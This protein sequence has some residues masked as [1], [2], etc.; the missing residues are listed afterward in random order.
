VVAIHLLALQPMRPRTF[1]SRRNDAVTLIWNNQ[2][3]PKG[4]ESP[5]SPQTQIPRPFQG[6]VPEACLPAILSINE[7]AGKGTRPIVFTQEN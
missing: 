5:F 7:S 3:Y 4:N 6:R 2:K 1:R